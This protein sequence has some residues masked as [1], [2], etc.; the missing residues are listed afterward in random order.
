MQH[1]WEQLRRD[2]YRRS[3]LRRSTKHKAESTRIASSKLIMVIALKIIL[4]YQADPY[5]MDERD[6]EC[7]FIRG[8]IKEGRGHTFSSSPNGFKLKGTVWGNFYTPR[9]HQT[10]TFHLFFSS[11]FLDLLR[12]TMEAELLKRYGLRPIYLQYF[13]TL[14]LPKNSFYIC[15]KYEGYDSQEQVTCWALLFI[16]HTTFMLA[17]LSYI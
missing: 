2:R 8:Q 15:F 1:C 9:P 10:F 12:W 11:I 17:L 6:I 14:F 4:F 5:M 3:P 7:M 16:M 13:R